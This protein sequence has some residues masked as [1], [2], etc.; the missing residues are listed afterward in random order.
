[1]TRHMGAVNSSISETAAA[2][3]CVDRCAT[4]CTDLLKVSRYYCTK[5]ALAD[6]MYSMLLT[7]ASLLLPE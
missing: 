3:H 6:Q 5:G 4:Y 7:H 1:M 2:S